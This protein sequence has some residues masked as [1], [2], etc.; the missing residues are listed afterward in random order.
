MVTTIQTIKTASNW[1]GQLQEFQ[2]SLSK[3]YPALL[4]SVLQAHRHIY[5]FSH[6]CYVLM[7]TALTPVLKTVLHRCTLP[8]AALHATHG[9]AVTTVNLSAGLKY[10][11]LHF[12]ILLL[13]CSQ[14]W[15]PLTRSFCPFL[16]GEVS[17]KWAVALCYTI[18][19]VFGQLSCYRE[20][21]S[22]SILVG[23]MPHPV[24]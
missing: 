22:S 20:C 24:F 4:H 19:W 10:C 18:L 3:G 17:G 6:F 2:E 21:A 8:L 7:L 15:L 13:S 23:L 9:L 14:H 16:I 11:L 5:S 12:W 1:T